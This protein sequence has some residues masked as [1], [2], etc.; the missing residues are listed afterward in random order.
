[1]PAQLGWFYPASDLGGPGIDNSLPGVPPRPPHQS[2]PPGPQD[3]GYDIPLPPVTIDNTLPRPPYR[4]DQGL[5]YPP[6]YIDNGLPP[7]YPIPPRLDNSL[8]QPP[9]MW[10]TP[11]WPPTTWP[12]PSPIRPELPMFPL[13]PDQSLPAPP[14]SVWPPIDGV[15]GPV[16]V[17]VWVPGH[18]YRWTVIDPSLSIGFPL[19]ERPPHVGGGP[20]LTPE[21]KR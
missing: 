17:L 1:M 19:P 6:A 3:P 9:S 20:A 16:L 11:P 5:P 4:P 10:P 15:N 2:L 12:P 13:P 8:P 18:G 21:P 7:T 14:G